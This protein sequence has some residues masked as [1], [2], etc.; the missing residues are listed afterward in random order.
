MAN[1]TAT[2]RKDLATSFASTQNDWL[3][4][5]DVLT[6]PNMLTLMRLILIIPILLVLFYW[7][8]RGIA[9]T[10]F[11]FGA[12]LDILD[13]LIAHK[14]NRITTLGRILDPTVD[15]FFYGAILIS[16]A[17]LGELVSWPVIIAAVLQVLRWIVGLATYRHLNE[18]VHTKSIRYSG[19][20]VGWLLSIGITLTFLHMPLNDLFVLLGIFAFYSSTVLLT[21]EALRYYLRRKRIQH[22]HIVHQGNG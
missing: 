16:F 20:L 15:R 11:L 17:I 5:K 13:G 3:T 2:L 22:S 8:H 12:A 1:G 7:D 10:L 6:V 21:V 19:R 14:T 9:L 18:I 4:S